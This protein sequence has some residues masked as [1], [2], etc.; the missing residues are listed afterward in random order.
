MKYAKVLSD[1]RD[2]LPLRGDP[3]TVHDETCNVLAKHKSGAKLSYQTE[4]ANTRQKE[5]NT[6]RE[7]GLTYSDIGLRLGVSRERVR[8]VVSGDTKGSSKRTARDRAVLFLRTA[9]VARLL[10][11]HENTVRRWA[12]DGSLKSY[13]VGK[14]GD[15]RFR[16]DDV[17]RALSRHSV[18]GGI[19]RQP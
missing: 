13:R 11:I 12:D 14:R 7:A 6:L 19:K 9:D 2:D 10:G 18:P 5:M 1:S 16:R 3:T 8:Q 17:E 4:A 15:R